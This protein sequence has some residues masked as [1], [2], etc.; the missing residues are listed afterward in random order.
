[1]QS[2]GLPFFASFSIGADRK[3]C[4]VVGL[5]WPGQHAHR[6][7]GRFLQNS[8]STALEQKVEREVPVSKT[9]MNGKVLVSGIVLILLAIAVYESLLFRTL[10]PA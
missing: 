10:Q 7:G 1:M 8:I 5:R 9:S 4:L 3:P 2:F 6:K